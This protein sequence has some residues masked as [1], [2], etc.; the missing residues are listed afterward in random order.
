MSSAGFDY[1]AVFAGNVP[2]P[3]A[4]WTGFPRY[5]FVGGHNDPDRIPSE[6]LAEA[7]ASVLRREGASLATYGLGQGPLGHVGL[8][9]FIAGKSATHRGIAATADDVL[10]TIGSMQGIDL[11]NRLLV[12]P[13]DTVIVEA[14]TFHGALAKLRKIGANIVGAPLDAQG[15]RIDA[16]EAILRDLKARGVQPKYIYTIPTIQN[17]TGS[18]LPLD[19]RHA[20]LALAREYGVPVFEDECYADLVWTGSAPPA[21]YA[22]DPA[23]VIHIGS[24]SKSLAPALRLGFAIAP[25]N[26]LGR[27]VALRSDGPGA[28]EQLVVAEYFTRHFD[29]HVQRLTTGLR[30][31]LD[32]LVE[33]L[34][35]E[36]GTAVEFQRPE[37]GI[38]LWLRLA[39][40][41]D[42]RRLVKPA[43]DAGIA[44]NP[45]PEWAVDPDAAASWLRLCFALPSHADIREGVAAFA[46]V[47]AAVTGIPLRRA[48]VAAA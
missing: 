18:V 13:G 10:I 24:F 46:R 31:K 1:S 20:L 11:V 43:A 12:E 26:V 42:V 29:D 17:P 36:F 35:R 47:S 16:L 7:A 19:R 38:Y 21:L 34:E 27:L 8:R 45:G 15:L 22:L 37:G 9:D 44:F 48:N 39:E 28:L 5:N 30:A 40:G 6:G 32:T 2:A 33:A 23:Q 14:L 41:V 25:W 4:R 3:A